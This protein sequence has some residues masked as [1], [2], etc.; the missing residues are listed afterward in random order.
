MIYIGSHPLNST[1]PFG[2]FSLG[3]NEVFYAY[4]LAPINGGEGHFHLRAR[5]GLLIV[6]ELSKNDRKGPV[7]RKK[8]QRDMLLW[9]FQGPFIGGI[10]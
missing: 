7:F 6:D 8:H 1:L 2:G 3:V 9:L 5:S 10:L 4:H